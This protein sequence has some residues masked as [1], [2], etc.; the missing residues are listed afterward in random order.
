MKNRKIFY[1]KLGVQLD[2]TTRFPSNYLF[3]FIV[4]AKQ[5]N[6]SKVVE[7]FDHTQ[8]VITKKK[9]RNGK[10]ISFSIVIRVE[11]SSEVINYYKRA[12]KIE[13]IIAL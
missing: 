10:Y 13:G 5:D 12:E 11:N 8:A 2:N 1:G 7:I 4:P 9:S 3:K 6:D